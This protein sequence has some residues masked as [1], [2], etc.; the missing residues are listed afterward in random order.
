[1]ARRML[2]VTVLLV[3]GTLEDMAA[4]ARAAADM[5]SL[6]VLPRQ[7]GMPSLHPSMLCVRHTI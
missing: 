5:A 4:V 2:L 6:F 3:V 1:M 7:D